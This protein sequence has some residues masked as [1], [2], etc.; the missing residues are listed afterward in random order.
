MSVNVQ[1]WATLFPAI[2]M[3]PN[4]D[5]FQFSDQLLLAKEPPAW[6]YLDKPFTISEAESP[7]GWIIWYNIYDYVYSYE[8]NV[9][10]NSHGY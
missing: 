2:S 8:I 6:F 1:N 7:G 9:I 3:S 4:Q 10:N 5:V